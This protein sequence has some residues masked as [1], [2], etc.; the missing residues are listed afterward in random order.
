MI[1]NMNEK[2]RQ[3]KL[4]AAIAIIAM[5]V[6]AFAVVMPSDNVDG[7]PTDITS[8]ITKSGGAISDLSSNTVVLSGNVSFT[9]TDAT[10]GL[11]LMPGASVT[12]DNV[13]LTAGLTV[14]D[15]INGATTGAYQTNSY[16]IIIPAGTVDVVISNVNGQM[17][18]SGTIS[19]TI[20]TVSNL[21]VGADGFT[22]TSATAAVPGIGN[23][24]LKSATGVEYYQTV[25]KT[26]VLK[27]TDV[28]T[29]YSGSAN[30]SYTYAS[31]GSNVTSVIAINGIE[32]SSS[33][34]VTHCGANAYSRSPSYVT[35]LL[36]LEVLPEGKA[37]TVSPLWITP[38]AIFPLNPLK[39]RSGRRT[40]CTG[41]RKL[42]MFMSLSIFTVSRYSISDGPS[43]QGVRALFSTT[44]SPSRAESGIQR[45]SSRPR[46]PANLKYSDV[47]LSYLSFEKS[48]RSILFTARTMCF[49]PRRDTR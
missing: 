17:T 34:T 41:K 38:D 7:A 23:A 6:C 37:M 20:A 3:T 13:T 14:Y 36:I 9:D 4:L 1:A 16:G 32:T 18:I 12:I 19:G 47:M 42:S 48:T 25:T 27:T 33:V 31:G 35:I 49:I 26:V 15:A 2:G 46:L 8:P 40:Y 45:M 29:I 28:F 44:L 43:Y 24:A 21:A 10:N 39:L 5:V 30:V 11:Y 22:N